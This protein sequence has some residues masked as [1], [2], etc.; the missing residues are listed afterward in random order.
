MKKTLLLFALFVT[1]AIASKAQS[2]YPLQDT[3]A[4][5]APHVPAVHRWN[6]GDGKKWYSFDDIVYTHASSDTVNEWIT[7]YPTEAEDFYNTIGLYLNSTDVS[8]LSGGEVNLYRDAQA[9][10][11]IIHGRY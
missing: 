10:W 3:I 1:I 11:L 6:D 2:A 5:V 4:A 9:V 7:A 8:T